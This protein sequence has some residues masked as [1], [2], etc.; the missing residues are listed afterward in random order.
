MTNASRNLRTWKI[1]RFEWVPMHTVPVL[2]AI[3]EVTN[4]PVVSNLRGIVVSAVSTA[5]RAP[6]D[7]NYR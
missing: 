3:Y 5:A 7:Y 2:D 1:I 6:A 4:T